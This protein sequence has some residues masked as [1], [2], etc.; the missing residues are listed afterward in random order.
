MATDNNVPN[1]STSQTQQNYKIDIEKVY[2][3]I[4]QQIDASRSVINISNKNNQS[5]LNSLSKKSLTTLRARL[6]VEQTYQES[7]CHAFYRL[8][9]FPV[10][11]KDNF[12]NP[13]LN[14]IKNWM[15]NHAPKKTNMTIEVKL[16]IIKNLV[17]GFRELSLFRE[18]YLSDIAKIFNSNTTIDA[19]TLALSS[20]T[21]TRPFSKAS[22]KITPYTS[23]ASSAKEAQH[24]DITDSIIAQGLI[25]YYPGSTPLFFYMDKSG[26]LPTKL[27][28]SRYHIIAPFMVDPWIDFSVCPNSR[29]IAVPFAINKDNL[30]VGEDTFVKRPLIE[31]I[32]R[33]RFTDVTPQEQSG[34]YIASL[35]DFV[36][37]TPSIQ[38]EY[39]INFAI[40]NAQ[41]AEQAQFQNYLNIILSMVSELHLAQQKIREVQLQYYWLPVPSNTG[42]EGGVLVRP[43]ISQFSS[44]NYALTTFNDTDLIKATLKDA[45][46]KISSQVSTI[47]G[48]P[49]VGGFALTSIETFSPDT[50]EAYGDKN[51]EF[52]DKA[53]KKRDKLMTEAG[54][55]LR[56]VEIIMG[57]FG[58]LGL[59]DIIAILGSLYIMPKE[60]ILGFLD[61]DAFSRAK[62]ALKLTESKPEL[63]DTLDSF[64]STVKDFYTLMDKLYEDEI[65]NNN[66]A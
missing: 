66:R 47:T 43:L 8:I 27:S 33:D 38:D 41:A 22:E 10:V 57:E 36:E 56:V 64:T 30:K 23:E 28:S 46:N 26:N 12:Y 4:I 60:K 55:A 54:D 1:Q 32:I 14:N 15:E 44:L 6:K 29:L 17:P 62:D 51:R 49:D 2:T 50:T 40:N 53:S 34:E 63:A 37:N 19:S 20:S 45:V 11:G 48:T 58:G 7:R 9:G 42:P 5:V 24:Y 13:G 59:C 16:D 61:T 18:T 65:N 52:L 31:K 35:K 21:I 3:D 39:L 25:G